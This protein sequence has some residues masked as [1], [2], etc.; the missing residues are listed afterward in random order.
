MVS[1]LITARNESQLNR[2]IESLYETAEA[3]IEVIV[4]LDEPQEV[5]SRAIAIHHTSPVGRRIGTNE[6]AKLASGEHLFILDAHCKM[7]NGW[8]VK[9][10]ESCPEK[11]IVVSCIQDM[12]KD[13][14]ELRPGLYNHVYLSRGY[15]EKWWS[16]RPFK[17]TEEM[18]CFTGC[19]WMIPKEYYWK[20]N[21]YD[22]SL[23]FY[24]WDGPEWA[25]KTWMG[26]NPGKVMLRSDVICGHVFGTNEHNKLYRSHGI[27]YPNYKKYMEELYS[28]KIEAFREKFSPVPDEKERN[29][30]T[31]VQKVD[32]VE[33]KQGDNTIKIVK[34]HYKPYT[35]KHDGTK[36]EKEIEA[37]VL[38][39]IT[40]IER[41]EVMVG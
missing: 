7:S 12:H 18:M 29:I 30:T 21:G 39:L 1:V 13:T 11:G 2:T 8:D 27:G 16:R 41:E 35:V 28:D 24:G 31:V 3:G 34:R 38:D 36:S 9:M 10:A 20:C 22:E 23:G 37:S 25:C 15:E 40:E 17:V 33:A 6:A 14:W 19:S 4:S 32:T 5:D 26:D